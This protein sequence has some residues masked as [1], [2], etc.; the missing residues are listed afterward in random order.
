MTA[1]ESHTEIEAKLLAPGE[2]TLFAIGKLRSADSYALR[3]RRVARL[4]TVYLDSADFVLLRSRSTVR[5]RRRGNTWEATAKQGGRVRGAVHER[6]EVTVALPGK[7]ALPFVLP[8][9]PLRD[10]VG[11]TVGSRE[12]RPI[13]ITEIRRRALDAFAAGD[14]HR[15][16]A[17][18]ALDQTR[19]RLPGRG[20]RELRFCEVEIE[21]TGG[22]RSDV[23]RL[24]ACLR[25]LFGLSPSRLS[26]FA[27]GVTLL[28]GSG[29][30]PPRRVFASAR[31]P[32]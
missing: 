26:K 19:I 14:A 11:A 15:P 25:R 23:V 24:A 17:E 13:L 7:P 22:S 4:S 31:R 12:L 2:A 28:R 29:Q 9:G 8:P 3:P 6:S 5:L 32:Q 10:A 18:I 21:A 20:G 27:R 1:T 16:V 30:G